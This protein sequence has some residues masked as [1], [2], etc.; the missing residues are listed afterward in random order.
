MLPKSIGENFVATEKG[1]NV[2][3]DKQ[4][5]LVVSWL[6]FIN[7]PFSFIPVVVVDDKPQPYYFYLYCSICNQWISFSGTISNFK[8]HCNLCL[9]KMKNQFKLTSLKKFFFFN[10]LP[11]ILIEDCDIQQIF[12][13]A[14]CRQT[15]VSELLSLA[16]HVQNDI[17]N[18]IQFSQ[19]ASM[20]LDEWS[21]CMGR[22]YLGFTILL[23]NEFEFQKIDLPLVRIMCIR[24]GSIEMFSIFEDI[25]NKYNLTNKLKCISSDTCNSMISLSNIIH[26]KYHISWMPCICHILDLLIDAFMNNELFSDV[27]NFHRTWVHSTQLI[28]FLEK[29][30]APF[31]KIPKDC[32]TRWTSFSR[33]VQVL[34]ALF[35][36]IDLFCLENNIHRPNTSILLILETFEKLF[37]KYERAILELQC[38]EFGIISKVIPHITS[39]VNEVNKLPDAF[40]ESKIAFMG[41]LQEKWMKFQSCWSPILYEASFL[42]P[43]IGWDSIMSHETRNMVY[44]FILYKMKLL[45]FEEETIEPN[46]D[47]IFHK[48]VSTFTP[49]EE[50]KTYEMMAA[51]ISSVNLVKYWKNSNFKRLKIIAK[52][53]LSMQITSA[54]SERLFSCAGEIM[55]NKRTK[56]CSKTLIAAT[57]VKANKTIVKKYLSD[58]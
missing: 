22:R 5:R 28:V 54:P 31:K 21:D 14:P 29:N 20:T 51:T 38:N 44:N 50:I 7:Y 3:Y 39:I 18:I 25:I 30:N 16:D 24:C 6:E 10:A 46:S 11:F 52:E 48:N 8:R 32:N 27:F 42:N 37:Q 33:I 35:P 19:S 1:P 15:L 17:F 34:I 12:P 58:K 2:Q 56:M 23:F 53:I 49:E 41:K 45:Q 57:F 4:N 47:E 26:T 9:K 43:S 13:E 36:F 40:Y 55:G